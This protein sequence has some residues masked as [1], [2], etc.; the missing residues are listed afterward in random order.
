MTTAQVQVQA[1]LAAMSAAAASSVKLAADTSGAVKRLA[2]SQEAALKA[3]AVSAQAW[4]TAN[5]PPTPV[6]TPTPP[7]TPT[8]GVGPSGIP[9][10]TTSP[11]GWGKIL[12]SDDFTTPQGPGPW[13][14]T[15]DGGMKY[16]GGPYSS[17]W[18]TNPPGWKDTSGAGTYEYQNLS[19][20]NSCLIAH[21]A[22]VS[23][24][25]QVACPQP[26]LNGPDT[27]GSG[28][29]Y[30]RYDVCFK[31][32][33]GLGG[34]K[35]AFLLWPDDEVWA[36]GEVDFPEGDLG[37]TIHGYVHNITGNPSHNDLGVSTS[38]TYT[39]W[40]VA[41][42]EWTA[43]GVTFILD[44]KNLGSTATS[45]KVPMHWNLQIETDGGAPNSSVAGNLYVDWVAAY[46][47]A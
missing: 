44:D 13:P 21:L 26:L 41:T 30:G 35:T 5:Y 45:P 36:D 3:A 22:T 42:I 7:P 46:A 20:S 12:F 31:A 29:L 17:R 14:G 37:S 34:F 39:S 47:P 18:W 4:L 10:P 43:A 9:M 27:E 32:D 8:P 28:S 25:P 2:L 24:V 1:D 19:V 38:T 33:S 23:G 15:W 6:P 11:A 16:S 40:H